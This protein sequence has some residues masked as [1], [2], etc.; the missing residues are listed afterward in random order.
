MKHLLDHIF[1]L[2]FIFYYPL[3]M[4]YKYML[5][6]FIGYYFCNSCLYFSI[7]ISCCDV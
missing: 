2:F 6:I 1:I 3:F 5:C 4:E 7:G